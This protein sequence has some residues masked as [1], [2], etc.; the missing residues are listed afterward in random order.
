VQRSRASA[1]EG[2]ERH[3]LLVLQKFSGKHRAIDEEEKVSGFVSWKFLS[4]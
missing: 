2:V 3:R 1:D 4:Y